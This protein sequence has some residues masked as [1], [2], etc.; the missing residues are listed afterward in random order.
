MIQ[1]LLFSLP[2]VDVDILKYVCML[3]KHSILGDYL[4]ALI[5]TKFLNVI[6]A[7]EID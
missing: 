1:H 7:V 5:D 4:K 3:F 6:T 2:I